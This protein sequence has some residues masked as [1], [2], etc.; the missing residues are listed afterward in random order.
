MMIKAAETFH[1]IWSR[2]TDQEKRQIEKI[3]VRQIP[4]QQALIPP[5]KKR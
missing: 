5:A 2:A 4:S 1:L 3:I